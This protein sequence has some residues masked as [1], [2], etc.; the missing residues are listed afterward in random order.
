MYT[1]DK[2]KGLALTL[3]LFFIATYI[4]LA[5]LSRNVISISYYYLT[6]FGQV[7]C[8]ILKKGWYWQLLT[9]IFVH[10]NLI[11]LFFNS[12]FMYIVGSSVERKIGSKDM[13]LVFLGSALIGNFFSL[14]MGP[15]YLVTAGAS[16][17]IL[18][19]A[20]FDIIYT[21]ILSSSSLMPAVST[22][23]VLFVMNSFLPGVNVLGHLGGIVGGALIGYL[24]GRN[25]TKRIIRY[26]TGYF[27]N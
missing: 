17:G 8:F 20:A 26:G 11:H 27:Y 19:L 12:F 2:R 13:F 6:L 15:I 18:G 4:V 1:L 9:S 16:G 23:I 24:Y 3:S 10:V 14:I 21:K 7:N 5:L 22:L 25:K